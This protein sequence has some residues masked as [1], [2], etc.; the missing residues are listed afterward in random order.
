MKK[1]RLFLTILLMIISYQVTFSQDKTKPEDVIKTY[2]EKT[3]I[4][5]LN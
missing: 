5:D 4:L 3:K 1:S 2:F